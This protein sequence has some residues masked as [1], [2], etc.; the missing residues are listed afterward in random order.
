MSILL[1]VLAAFGLAVALVEKGDRFPV[2]YIAQPLR[3]WLTSLYEP[4]GDLFDCSVCMSFWA[5][6]VVDLLGCILLG[7]SFL[8]PLTGFAALGL[9]W[10]IYEFLGALKPVDQEEEGI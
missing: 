9:T 1:S 3:R 10:L 4:I 6:F 2:S 5:A 7:T 8:W